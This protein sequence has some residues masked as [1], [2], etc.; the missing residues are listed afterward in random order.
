MQLFVLV[1]MPAK[2]MTH[3]KYMMEESILKGLFSEKGQ[4]KETK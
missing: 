3:S 4:G 2:N 1:K